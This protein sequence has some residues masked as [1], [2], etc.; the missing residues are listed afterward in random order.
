M[1]WGCRFS[2]ACAASFWALK[3]ALIDLAAACFWR[4]S[5]C[6]TCMP[7]LA[8]C[9]RALDMMLL[10]PQP[11]LSNHRWPESVRDDSRAALFS[12]GSNICQW[13]S[14]S[15]ILRGTASRFQNFTSRGEVVPRKRV[16]IS[17]RSQLHACCQVETRRDA[18]LVEM[19]REVRVMCDKVAASCYVNPSKPWYVVFTQRCNQNKKQRSCRIRPISLSMFCC[20]PILP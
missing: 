18:T 5:S 10:Q 19:R 9:L 11:L 4:E 17:I 16:A 1:Y 3:D 14:Y 7:W 15:S 20:H 2:S 6:P 13:R 8:R 12:V